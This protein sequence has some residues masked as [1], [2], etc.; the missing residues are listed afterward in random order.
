MCC[1]QITT[2]A[3]AKG[4]VVDFESG[5]KG[6]KEWSNADLKKHEVVAAVKDKQSEL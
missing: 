5:G 2:S 4:M 6:L 1:A 3:I